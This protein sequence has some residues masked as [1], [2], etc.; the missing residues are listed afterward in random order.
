MIPASDMSCAEG[1]EHAMACI[2]EES[3][4]ETESERE[5]DALD[6]L[7]DTNPYMTPLRS[8]VGE[9]VMCPEPKHCA[10]ANALKEAKAAHTGGM[11]ESHAF[12]LLTG[13]V[14]QLLNSC[15]PKADSNSLLVPSR[16]QF[17][18]GPE[19]CY[20]G[21]KK[22]AT[23][24]NFNV[25]AF[26]ESLKEYNPAL[27]HHY[28]KNPTQFSTL[29]TALQKVLGLDEV[30]IKRASGCSR[31]SI[32]SWSLQ[33]DAVADVS[34]EEADEQRKLQEAQLA[35]ERSTGVDVC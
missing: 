32:F 35:R 23:S 8:L 34:Q 20:C 14:R 2:V 6:G 29:R 17:Q 7:Q 26:A 28:V 15:E 27:H 5:D 10:S 9:Q 13:A 22:Q 11:D 18:Q 1:E 3:L 31:E 12:E 4:H 25:G 16:Q 19:R 30:E 33:G 21:K 24:C